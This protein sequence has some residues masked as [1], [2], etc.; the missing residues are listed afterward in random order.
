MDNEIR[1]V[2][3]KTASQPFTYSLTVEPTDRDF[4][5]AWELRDDA[6]RVDYRFDFRVLVRVRGA[7]SEITIQFSG[8]RVWGE[9][10]ERPWVRL[11]LIDAAGRVLL[12]E[13]CP[14][15]K[16]LECNDRNTML[17]N[18]TFVASGLGPAT[19]TGLRLILNY[20]RFMQCVG[21][22]P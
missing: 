17:F 12:P 9:T 4:I 15:N 19:A 6:T 7:D 18:K 21:P 14:L 11:E 16:R 22:N 13:N 8:T 3:T 10:G 5:G 2:E 20:D 1:L